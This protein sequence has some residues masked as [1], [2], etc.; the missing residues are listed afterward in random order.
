M[1]NYSSLAFFVLKAF[2]QAHRNFKLVSMLSVSSSHIEKYKFQLPITI[3][4][5]NS[6]LTLTSGSVSCKIPIE[7]LDSL[8]LR[9]IDAE[10]FIGFEVVT[11]TSV[12]NEPQNGY[13]LFHSE[14][15]ASKGQGEKPSTYDYYKRDEDSSYAFVVVSKSGP[16]AMHRLG[17]L[18]D[19]KSL[20]SEVFHICP[21]GKWFTRG[22]LPD[23]Y[24]RDYAQLCKAALDI[25][26]KEGILQRKQRAE[27][28]KRPVYEYLKA[29]LKE[30]MVQAALSA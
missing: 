22:E 30:Q 23:N 14:K 19:P 8:N 1:E 15:S 6:H 24:S 11:Q 4:R 9:S 7:D 18:S 21:E 29:P 10:Q 27:F 28:N 13:K 20:I 12:E 25:L 16:S 5:T 3:K 2:I 26:C 17:S